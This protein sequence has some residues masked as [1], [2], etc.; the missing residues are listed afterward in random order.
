MRNLT[1][2]LSFLKKLF[3]IIVLF[4]S[5]KI[6]ATH[7][8]GGEIIYRYAGGDN[9]D[10]TLKVYRDCSSPT[11]FDGLTG[12]TGGNI[13]AALITVMDANGVLINVFNIGAPVVKKIPPTINNPCIETPKNICVEEGIYSI[14]LTLPPKTGG[15]YI[16]YQRCCRNVT[17]L[18]LVNSGTQGSTYFTKIPGPEVAVNN[19]S[20]SFKNFPPIFL[21]NN[22]KF[23]FDHSALDPDAGDVLV[24]SLCPPFLGLDGCCPSLNAGI[25]GVSPNCP[26]PPAICPGASSA[27]P[28]NAVNF[29]SPYNSAYPIASNPSITIDP[30]TGLLTGS[31]NLIGQYVVG[32]CVQEFRNNVLINTHY[33]DFQ[34]NI[35]SCIVS[36]VSQVAE[37][38]KQCFGKTFTFKNTST[39]SVGN[40]TYLW[41]FGDPNLLNDTSILVNPTYTYQDTGRYFITLIANPRKPCADT[42]KKQISIYPALSIDFNAPLQQCLKNN[43]FSFSALGV[44]ASL[45]EFR[46]DFP[47]GTNPPFSTSKDPPAIVFSK[48]GF[49]KIK[50]VAR[51]FGCRDSIIDSVKVIPRPSAS[52]RTLPA[53][54]C[55]PAKI[56][57]GNNSTSELPIK[58]YWNFS[59][60]I[61]SSN[62]ETSQVFSPWGVYS[63][64]LTAVTTS[65]CADTSVT[66]IS[67]ITVFPSPS[68]NFSYNPEITSIFEPEISIVNKA[69]WDA[70]SWQYTF[71][72]GTSSF[73]PVERHTYVESGNFVIMQTVNNKFGCKDSVEKIVQILPEFRFW[74][75]NAFTP[76]GNS[77]NDVF[78]PVLYGIKQYDFRIYDR[79][80]NKVFETRDPD[81]GWNGFF[82]DE[83]CKQDIYAWRI[84]FMNEI[85]SKV[86]VRSGHVVILKNL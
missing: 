28:Y 40:L 26:N 84:S 32:V 51:Q 68:A 8:V 45:A 12:S 61:K 73:F 81:K 67:N 2:Y 80:G 14:T 76:D 29:V 15:Y 58:Y 10:I 20:P 6:Y 59:T 33:R 19:S 27:P 37:P 56:E 64:T 22:L 54:L 55:D 18:N 39:S 38:E 74:I 85:N 16:V 30:N 31:P 11:A 4:L 65:I 79:W 62:F 49:Q 47:L 7:I 60:G 57:F 63:V 9:Y 72:D 75:P 78:K 42:L 5:F 50:L 25:A 77:R 53:L 44:F 70:L 41:D 36:V 23:N 13:M 71:G 3:F 46:W 24:Y 17:I 52:I 21:C 48:S 86:E 66:S 34:F 43:S 69:S 1:A 35:V 83:L 82:K